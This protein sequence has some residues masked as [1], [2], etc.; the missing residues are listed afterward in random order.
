MDSFLDHVILA[1]G[2]HLA[3]YDAG[4]ANSED[5]GKVVFFLERSTDSSYDSVEITPNQAR[6]LYLLLPRTTVS[7]WCEW[8]L[9]LG[10]MTLSY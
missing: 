9:A 4:F 7:Q 3:A 8:K 2:L 10:A 5:E 6:A 1:G